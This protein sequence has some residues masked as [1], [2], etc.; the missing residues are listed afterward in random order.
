M[1]NGKKLRIGLIAMSG[2]RVAD[3]ELMRKGLTFPGVL[4]RG[5][6]VGSLPSLS[7]LT[8]AGMTPPDIEIEYHEIRDLRRHGPLPGRFD[9]VAISS[10]SAQV[11]EA[12][13]VARWYRSRGIPSVMG[14]LHVTCCPDEALEHCSTVVVGEGELSWPR[15]IEDFRHGRLKTR[16][17]PAPG[18]SFDLR[19]APMPRFDLLDLSRYTRLTVQTTR[20]CPHQCD[21]CA[22]SILLTSQYKRKPVDR[23]IA[24]IRAIKK[25][26]PKP[27]IEFADDNSFVHRAHARELLEALRE[28]RVSWFT[29]VDISVAKDPALLDLMRAGGC[30]QVL[31]GLESPDREGLDGL[32][33]RANWKLKQLDRYEAAVRTIQTHGI[34]VNGCFILGLDGDDEGIFDRVYDFVDRTNLYDVQ[35]TVLTPFPGTPLYERLL[36]EGRILRPGAWDHCTLFDV[37]YVP[38]DM[39]PERLQQGLLELAER[40]YDEDFV[41]S[42]R[43]RF[44]AQVLRRPISRR[45]ERHGGLRRSA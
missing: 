22:S 38:T 31:I 9:L 37:N 24:E 19:F 4:E 1:R 44:F 36:R 16:Y 7:L 18:E 23:I 10:L 8:L 34:T 35:L 14:G 40:V 32:E 6:V 45:A 39:S 28:E 41:R 29:E 26:W 20:G 3:P 43:E 42:R 13:E 27:F 21:F 30:R 2:I 17:E 15:V 11:F 5:R 12:Y 33:L 25:L